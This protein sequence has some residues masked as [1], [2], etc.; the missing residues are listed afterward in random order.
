MTTTRAKSC[1]ITTPKLEA[2]LRDLEVVGKDHY[3]D[4]ILG[5]IVVRYNNARGAWALPD[6]RGNR[7]ISD[8]AVAEKKAGAWLRLFERADTRQ[9]MAASV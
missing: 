7:W 9:K 3:N 6:G 8:R 5:P 4:I 1:A 2:A